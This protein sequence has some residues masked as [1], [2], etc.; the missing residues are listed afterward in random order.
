MR[1]ELLQ[2]ESVLCQPLSAFQQHREFVSQRKEARRLETDN[3]YA[4]C[5][6]IE[7]ALG[8][9]LRLVDHAGGKESPPATE[10]VGDLHP[11]AGCFQNRLRGACVLRLE[12]AV[13]RIDE[14]ND[15]AVSCAAIA[16]VIPAP[17]R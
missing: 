16:E 7:H 5:E 1:E 10:A 15:V 17:A 9:A 14:K 6:C 11:I 13:E 3:R 4:G 8:F 12:V 2:Q